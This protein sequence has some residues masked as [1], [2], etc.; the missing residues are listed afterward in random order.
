MFPLIQTGV[1][2]YLVAPHSDRGVHPIGVYFTGAEL[3][4]PRHIFRLSELAFRK[5]KIEFLSG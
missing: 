5:L 4:I 2:I 1:C 3:T